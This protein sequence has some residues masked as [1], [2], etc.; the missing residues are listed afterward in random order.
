MAR[1]TG[2]Y[3]IMYTIGLIQLPLI[4]QLAVW[5]TSIA[6]S[7]RLCTPGCPSSAVPLQVASYVDHIIW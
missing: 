1:G 5:S 3:D 6:A 7:D 2:M 4:M